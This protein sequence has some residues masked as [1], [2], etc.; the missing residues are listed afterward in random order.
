MPTAFD[1]VIARALAKDPADRYPSAGDLGRA[2]RAAAAGEQATV[3]LGSVA[4]G[5]AAS[6]PETMRLVGESAPAPTS[7][8]REPD[9]TVAVARSRRFP[10][11]RVLPVVAA[12]AVLALVVG[13]AVARSGNKPSGPLSSSE[14]A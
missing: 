1:A 4:R 14:V 5:P 9:K 7:V 11:R 2:A 12:L 10:L 6:E 13:I 8:L 3:S